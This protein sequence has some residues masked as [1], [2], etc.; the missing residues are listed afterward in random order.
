[1]R[2]TFGHSLFARCLDCGAAVACATRHEHVCDRERLV[3]HQLN[4]V[5]DEIDAYL[6]SPR[7]LF[8][9][10]WATR[11]RCSAD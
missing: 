4:G 3:E 5:E 8:E 9:S 2:L 10:W 1:M 11:E 7:G 6:A